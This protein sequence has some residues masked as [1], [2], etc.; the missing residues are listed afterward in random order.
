MR[1]VSISI[2]SF[3]VILPSMIPDLPV[4]QFTHLN[5]IFSDI[6]YKCVYIHYSKQLREHMVGTAYLV[7]HACYTLCILYAS[8]GLFKLCNKSR[9]HDL[10]GED[11]AT[12]RRCASIPPYKDCIYWF[13]KTCTIFAM[14]S[15]KLMIIKS[16]TNNLYPWPTLY[17][18]HS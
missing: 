2:F 12:K 7:Y 14:L 9:L 17:F 4:H 15:Y 8:R 10:Y 11:N 6:I 18:T 3:H 13:T 5:M 1:E 16:F